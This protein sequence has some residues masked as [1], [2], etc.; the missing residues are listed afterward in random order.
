MVK[1]G[2]REMICKFFGAVSECL[3]VKTSF[4]QH[5]QDRLVLLKKCRKIHFLPP[6]CAKMSLLDTDSFSET[7]FYF[8]KNIEGCS[9]WSPPKTILRLDIVYRNN[10]GNIEKPKGVATR[11]N[12]LPNTIHNKYF[13][14]LIKKTELWAK[15]L[16]LIRFHSVARVIQCGH[17]TSSAARAASPYSRQ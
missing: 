17:A 9:K 6:K 16:A 5:S 8:E 12:C 14:K 11:A 10:L 15:S 1:R 7:P 4:W 2:N 3:A 13:D